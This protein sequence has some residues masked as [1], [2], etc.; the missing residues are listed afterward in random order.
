MKILV[1]ADAC[2]HQI[3]KL[4]VDLG[5]GKNCLFVSSFAH[6][7]PEKSQVEY[8]YVDKSYQAADMLIANRTQ[9]GDVIVTQ[10]YGL[11]TLVLAKGGKAISTR[12]MVY[13]S[14]NIDELLEQRHIMGKIRKGGGRHSGP[15]KLSQD[16]IDCFRK[17]F[18]RLIGSIR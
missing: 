9:A 3:K 15:A 13:S 17:N 12:G 2:P 7:S 8:L 11:A 18:S 16:D 10:D 6:F 1:D 4:I 14:K 5:R